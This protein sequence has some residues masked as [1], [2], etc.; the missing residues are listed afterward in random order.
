MKRILIAAV[1]A[2][3]GV[4]SLPAHARP[5]VDVQIVIGNAPPP[6]RYETVPA[7]RANRVWVPG[8]W[9]WTGHRHVWVAGHWERARAGHYY[10]PPQ[11]RRVHN[12]W[13]LDRGG[14]ERNDR[15]PPPRHAKPGP[16]KPHPHKPAPPRPHH[17]HRGHR[18]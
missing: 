8:Y 1:L 5:N 9:S 4:A 12:G 18:H 17:D 6:P 7:P 11:W 14:W 3:A 2:L 16:H 13:K 15:R 10:R